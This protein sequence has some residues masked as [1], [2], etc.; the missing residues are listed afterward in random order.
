MITFARAWP[1]FLV[2]QALLRWYIET[3]GA[4]FV[5]SRLDLPLPPC[6]TGE[7]NTAVITRSISWHGSGPAVIMEMES[8]AGEAG[9]RVSG[10]WDGKFRRARV[11]TVRASE[12]S[13]S[14]H[15]D[16]DRLA[17]RKQPF[18]PSLP[19]AHFPNA[20]ACSSS[21]SEGASCLSACQE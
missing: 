21:R 11:R 19:G 1:G 17:S 7:G 4:H 14:S 20:S 16:L 9:R 3:C 5:S 13:N 6:C 10:T 12:R 15:C 18:T 8:E 2:V